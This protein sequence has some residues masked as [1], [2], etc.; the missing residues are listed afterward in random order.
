METDFIDPDP[1]IAKSIASNADAQSQLCWTCG[2]CDFECPIFLSTERLRPQ[3]TVRMA[4]LGML[5]D[6]LTLP[7]IWYCLSCRRCLHGCPNNVKPYDL[8]LYLREEAIARG[9]VSREMIEPYRRLFIEFQRVRWRAVS[10]CFKGRLEPMSLQQWYKWLKTPIR[11]AAYNVIKAKPNG[12]N[13]SLKENEQACFTCSECSNC[14][15]IFG[16]RNVFDPQRIIR[17][18]NLGLSREVLK[19]PAIWLCLGCQRCTDACSQLVRGY[20]LI[21]RFQRQAVAEGFVD[22]FFSYWLIEADRIIY[23]QFLNQID[24]LLGMFSNIGMQQNT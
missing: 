24:T 12:P 13:A 15:P 11:T 23:P 9:I 19:S 7:E 20:D 5:D 14:C 1:D 16:E 17:M 18:A 21:R 8:H 6:L 2:T 3:K 10:H 22:P 4:N